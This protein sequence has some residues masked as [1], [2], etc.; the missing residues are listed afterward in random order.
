MSIRI[1]DSGKQLTGNKINRTEKHLGRPIP[2]AYRTFLLKH[3]GGHPDPSDF[4]MAGVHRGTTQIGTVRWFLG[5][6]VPEETFN[7][8]YVL[9]IFHDRVPTNLFPFALDPGGNLICIGAGGDEAGK[10]YFWD[11]EREAAEGEPP[12]DQNLYL[13]ADSFDDFLNKLGIV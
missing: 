13:I 10:V 3:N 6:N 11:H 2:P 9:E 12:T 1:L 5:I 8:E 7:L 4:R